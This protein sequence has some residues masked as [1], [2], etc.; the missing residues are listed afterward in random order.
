MQL[1][2]RHPLAPVKTRI[3]GSSSCASLSFVSFFSLMRMEILIPKTMTKKKKTGEPEKLLSSDE[4]LRKS[5][6]GC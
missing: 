3:V 4:R 5:L 1:L 2:V 6:K